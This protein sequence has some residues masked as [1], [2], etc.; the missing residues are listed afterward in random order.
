VLWL[1]V[2]VRVVLGEE[3]A[4]GRVGRHRGTRQ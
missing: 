1:L 2:R 4:R 3:K